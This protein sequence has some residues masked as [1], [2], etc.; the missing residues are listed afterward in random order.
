[1]LQLRSITLWEDS[2]EL[3][4]SFGI[5]MVIVMLGIRRSMH[6]IR[7]LSEEV[8][9]LEGGGLDYEI[10]VAGRDELAVLARGLDD[11]RRAFREQTERESYLTRSN[12]KMITEMSHDMRTP[13]T[14]MLLYT[15]IMRD[16]AQPGQTELLESID[17]V[18]SKIHQ[19][20]RMSENI[21]S[22]ALVS[23]DEKPELEQPEPFGMLFEDQLSEMAAWLEQNHYC[24]VRPDRFPA[25]KVSVRG[26]YITRILDNIVSNMQKYADPEYPVQIGCRTEGRYVVLSFINRRRESGRTDSTRIGLES[27]KKMMEQMQGSCETRTDRQDFEMKLRF[28]V[29]E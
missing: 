19:L 17:K 18:E 2:A 26:D 25:E 23:G 13:L 3:F 11:M 14:T 29:C 5:F 6:Y 27:V 20:Q 4:V 9:I 24:V 22:Y 10:T 21:L 1:M 16:Q 7:Q 12:Q 8:R 15:E 28:P